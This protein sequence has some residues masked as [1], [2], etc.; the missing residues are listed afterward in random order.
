MAI[1]YFWKLDGITGEAAASKHKG[2]IELHSWSWGAHNPTSIAGTGMSAG[3]VSI[4]DLSITKRLDKASPKLLGFCVTGDHADEQPL[5][6]AS[7]PAR[8]LR[9]TSLPSS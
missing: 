6:A 9:K 7:R 1:E 8:R 2:E 4:S 5:L 3:K